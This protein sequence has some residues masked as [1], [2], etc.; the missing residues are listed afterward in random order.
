MSRC[1]KIILTLAIV[2]GLGLSAGCS[3]NEEAADKSATE[4]TQADS[5]GEEAA[6]KDGEK[7]ADELPVEAT[8]PVATVNGVE[9]PASEFNEAIKLTAGMMQ[10]RPVTPQIAQMLKSNT[11]DRLIDMKLID[12]AL[13]KANIEVA[14]E[15]VDEELAKFKE[16]LPSAEEYEKF[17][18]ARG[19]TEAKMRENITKDRQLR[20]LLKKEYDGEVTEQDAKKMYDENK[21][22]FKHGAQV[23]ARHIL[24]NV[25]KD[26]DEAKVAETKKRAEAIAK[27]AK[28]PGADFEALA[29]EKSEGPTASRGGDLGYFEKSRMV[30]EFAE[31]AFAMKPG[32]ISDPVKSDFGFH[33]IQVVDKKE[34]GTT[35]FEEAKEQI[36]A[37]LERQKFG[38]SMNALLEDLK[39]D[40]KIEKNEDNIK[41]NAT[42]AEGAPAGM[43]PQQQMQQQIQQQ[44]QQQLQ[45]QQK[46]GGAKGEP[47]ELKLEE[48]SLGK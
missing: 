32:E 6:E 44:I 22:R 28:A 48:P 39:K 40:A 20:E 31:A 9:I 3:K 34:A 41:I 11:L 5:T 35:S 24:L 17:L 7:P 33:I 2:T 25:K 27:E 19:L 14:S 30:P 1:K 26:D 21:E 37:Q 46:E 12:A 18:E 47:T 38:E 15:E 23:H 45:E 16:R 10:G 42:A 43:D 36:I 4:A 29:K 8:G 13:E